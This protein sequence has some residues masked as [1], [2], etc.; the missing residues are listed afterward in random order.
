MRTIEEIL[1][2]NTTLEEIEE[3]YFGTVEVDFSNYLPDDAAESYDYGLWHKLTRD[4]LAPHASALTI[5]HSSEMLYVHTELTDGVVTGYDYALKR[6]SAIFN[7]NTGN[8]IITKEH[9]RQNDDGVG[10]LR[11]DSEAALMKILRPF[12]TR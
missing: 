1:N 9:A 3:E 7:K 8:Y 4:N 5:T 10:L 6:V 12:L 2:E 11:V